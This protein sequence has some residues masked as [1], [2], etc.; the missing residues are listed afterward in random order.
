M[1]AHPV[2]RRT[3][4]TDSPDSAA[5]ARSD[6]PSPRARRSASLRRSVQCRTLSAAVVTSDTH[7]LPLGVCA[8]GEVGAVLGLEGERFAVSERL[9]DGD[10][11]VRVAGDAGGDE[12][13]GSVAEN[14]SAHVHNVDTP[15]HDVN[16]V[17]GVS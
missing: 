1:T 9:D 12:A 5:S 13:G 17:D 10:A 4:S 7:G 3:P 11:V 15:T 16:N 2:M 14:V 6:A 8:R